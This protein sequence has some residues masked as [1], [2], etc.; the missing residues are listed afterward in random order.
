MRFVLYLLLLLLLALLVFYFWGRS[1]SLAKEELHKVENQTSIQRDRSDTLSVMTYNLGYLSGMTNNMP[2]D[3]EKSLFDQNLARAKGLLAKWDPDLIGFQEIDYG[4]HRSFQVDQAKSLS[5]A[6]RSRVKS[7]NW[8]KRYVP[9]PYWPPSVHFGKIVSGQSIFS[10]FP[11]RNSERIV[12]P[13]PESAPFYYRA[14]YLDR[15]IQLAEVTTDGGV[16]IVLNIHLEAFDEQTRELQASKVIELVEKYANDVPLILMGDFNARPPYATER[17]SQENTM[18]LFTDHPLLASAITKEEYLSAESQHFTF[19][20][21]KPYE[22][23]DY[24]FYNP[25]FVNPV[26]AVTLTE[27]GEISDHLPVFFT[28]TLKN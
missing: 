14:F 7:I 8:D 17:N 19:D 9:F 23:L 21:A 18:K 15:L 5:S 27:A 26:S 16:I 4:S 28:F 24:I 11:V 2:V 25:K 12:L 3:P 10:K 20:T 1:G 22:K 6:Y 13:G